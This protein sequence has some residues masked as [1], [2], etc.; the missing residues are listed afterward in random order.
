MKTGVV[1][2]A[3][4]SAYIEFEDTKMICSV[5]GPRQSGSE[6]SDK[7]EI[8]CEFKVA[9]F[10]ER[11]KRRGYQQDD[12]ERD[13]SMIVVHALEVAI[14]REKFPKSAID[15]NILVLQAS[16]CSFPSLSPSNPFMSPDLSS[17]HQI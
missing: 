6:F 16:G 8:N 9:T 7:A 11:H 1:S 2:Q 3:S 13:I 17:D 10:G 14:Q 15:I 12:E 4:G 5:Y